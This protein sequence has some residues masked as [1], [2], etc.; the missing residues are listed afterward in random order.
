MKVD[1]KTSKH[2]VVVEAHG[3]PMNSGVTKDQTKRKHEVGIVE[4]GGPDNRKTVKTKV[5]ERHVQSEP[6]FTTKARRSAYVKQTRQER[7]KAN[8]DS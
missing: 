2:A 1:T 8:F 6:G 7:E 3:V 5:G 4:L